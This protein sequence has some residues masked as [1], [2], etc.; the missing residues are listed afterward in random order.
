MV[1]DFIVCR[2]DVHWFEQPKRKPRTEKK[3]EKTAHK[4]KECWMTLK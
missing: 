2:F 1:R 3:R 4:K